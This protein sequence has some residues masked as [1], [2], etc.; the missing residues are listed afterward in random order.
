MNQNVAEVCII[1]RTNAGSLSVGSRQTLRRTKGPYETFLE[2]V[3]AVGRSGRHICI[4]GRPEN[5]H[6]RR[7]NA[8]VSSQSSTL[9][10]V[11]EAMRMAT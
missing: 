4:C 8:A 10:V 1:R 11:I 6:S 2:S 3:I 9:C 7:A 5:F